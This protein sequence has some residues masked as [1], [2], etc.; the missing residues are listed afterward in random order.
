MVAT[1][2]QTKKVTDTTISTDTPLPLRTQST[3]PLSSPLVPDGEST[4]SAP[5]PVADT[6][7]P[8][9]TPPLTET[10]RGRRKVVTEKSSPPSTEK[11]S[12][13]PIEVVLETVPESPQETEVP[14]PGATDLPRKRRRVVNK[15]L[16]AQSMETLFDEL[17]E[18]VT[19]KDLLKKLKQF[20]TDLTRVLKLKNVLSGEKQE[21]DVSNSG[22]MKPIK[23]SEQMRVFLGL[24]HDEVTRRLDIT[25]KLCEYI[26]VNNLQNP[27]DR[28]NIIPDET[29]KTLLNINDPKEQLTYYSIQQKLKDH[30][31]K[32]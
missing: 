14:L 22:F 29:L 4:G 7:T 13:V 27:Q 23:V 16:I 15:E 17:T 31:I 21:R 28:R 26:K 5:N 25:K 6:T 11:E 9:I 3:P 24:D 32:I 10:K 18:S 19:N 30:V 2:R 8:V 1:K 20:R 12:S